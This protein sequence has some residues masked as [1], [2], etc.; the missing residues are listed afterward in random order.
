MESIK[1]TWADLLAELQTLSPEELQ[2]MATFRNISTG[3]LIPLTD[4]I[5]RLVNTHQPVIP[6]RGPGV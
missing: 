4:G 3:D 2:Q 5:V 6:L 1:L